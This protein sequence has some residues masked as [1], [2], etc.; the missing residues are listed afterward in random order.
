MFISCGHLAAA[1]RVCVCVI[2]GGGVVTLNPL[3]TWVFC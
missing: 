1:P 2:G 3:W